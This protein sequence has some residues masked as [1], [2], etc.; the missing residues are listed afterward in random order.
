MSLCR[1]K[2]QHCWPRLL[3]TRIPKI[4]GNCLKITR[5]EPPHQQFPAR[6][7]KVLERCWSG[8]MPGPKQ[9]GWATGSQGHGTQGHA[10]IMGHRDTWWYVWLVQALR[11]SFVSHRPDPEY[12]TITTA[13]H[14]HSGSSPETRLWS[15]HT[16]PVHWASL[17]RP[18]ALFHL[19]LLWS[20]SGLREA[21]FL[22]VFF[23]L[24]DS[25]LPSPGLP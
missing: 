12:S 19:G 13:P 20:P 25:Q 2:C 10:G 16:R 3:W 24:E 1:G 11:G 6:T 18:S 15:L 22:C 21:H 23:F 17:L 8:G 7:Q 4:H 5:C 9:V 14:N